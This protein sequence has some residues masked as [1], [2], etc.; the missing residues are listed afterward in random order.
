[1]KNPMPTL[2][3]AGLLPSLSINAVAQVAEEPAAPDAPATPLAPP[4]PAA[5]SGSGSSSFNQK[6]V[7]IDDK[8]TGVSTRLAFMRDSTSGALVIPKDEAD[9]K[10][11]G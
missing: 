10:A 7:R 1:M 6:L 5:P 11:H 4:K 8:R 3:L 2:L 9:A